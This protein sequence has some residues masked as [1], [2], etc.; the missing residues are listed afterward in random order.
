MEGIIN[1]LELFRKAII[2]MFLGVGYT[3]SAIIMSQALANKQDWYKVILVT[4]FMN[5]NAT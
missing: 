5:C 2:S 1:K 4:S 3:V